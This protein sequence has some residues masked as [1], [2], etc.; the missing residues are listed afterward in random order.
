MI[1]FEL[2]IMNMKVFIQCEMVITCVIIILNSY[3]TKIM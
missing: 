3:I 2:V 1:D